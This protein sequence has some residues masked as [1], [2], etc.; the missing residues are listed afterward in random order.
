MNKA[1]VKE[2]DATAEVLP[3][4]EIS[5][6]PNLVT[7][8]G[9]AEI[10]AS[11]ARLQEQHAEAFGAGVDASAIARDLR[12]WTARRA[13]AQVT[14]AGLGSQVGFGSKVTVERSDGERNLSHRR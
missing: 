6:H 13:T 12:Y 7:S 1:F 8:E 5:P 4:R 11:I 10:D 14:E 2:D 9:L 3:D